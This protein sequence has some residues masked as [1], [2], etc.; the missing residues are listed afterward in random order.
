M[1]LLVKGLGIDFGHCLGLSSLSG[2]LLFL[3]VQEKLVVLPR[4][5]LCGLVGRF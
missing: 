5:I 3:D 2:Q 4:L 1:G